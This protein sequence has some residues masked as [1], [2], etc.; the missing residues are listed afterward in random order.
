M[1]LTPQRKRR[2]KIH[3]TIKSMKVENS[4]RV[5]AFLLTYLAY[6]CFHL[7]RK[8]PSIVKSVLHPLSSTGRSA[9]D[10]KTNPGWEPFNQDLVPEQVSKNGYMVTGS[11]DVRVDGKYSCEDVHVPCTKYVKPVDNNLS[12][13]LGIQACPLDDVGLSECWTIC[14]RQ[15]DT[16]T[17]QYYAQSYD[18][19]IPANAG[20]S[21]AKGVIH[22]KRLETASGKYVV[23][24]KLKTKPDSVDGGV[25]LGLLDSVFLGCYTV[26]LFI[27]GYIGDRMNLR[28]FLSIGMFG[29]SLCMFLMGLA[30]SWKIHTMSYFIGINVMFGFFQSVGWP[31]VVAVMGSWFGHGSRGFIMGVW[32]SHTSIGNILGSVITAAAVGSGMHHEDWPLGY[33]IPG[34]IM[35]VSASVVYCLLVPRPEDVGFVSLDTEDVG[36]IVGDMTIEEREALSYQQSTHVTLNSVDNGSR[37][38]P[39]LQTADGEEDD[40]SSDAGESSSSSLGSSTLGD[41]DGCCMTFVEA[42]SIPGLVP[43]SLSLM[44]SKMCAYSVLYWGPYYLGSLGFTPEKAGYLCSFFDVGGIFGGIAAGYLSD[45]L[46]GRAI[47]AFAFQVV[48]IPVMQAYYS[49]TWSAGTHEFTNVAMMILVGFFI[50]AP[51]ALI[52]TAVSAD[53]GTR[54]EGREHILALVTGIIDGTGSFGAMMQGYIVGLISS[55]SWETVWHFLMVAQAFS[56]LMLVRLVYHEIRELRRGRG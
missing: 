33:I 2:E 13:V 28:V 56:A 23:D 52:T 10:V 44:F 19:P 35:F 22:W 46:N 40:L 38:T 3:I 14:K 49:V 27:S 20:A 42:I 37:T 47:V 53:L 30:Y 51:Y 7:T 29:S 36:S 18:G 48:G 9:Y 11:D 8:V 55:S 15:N 16:C 43:F 1:G 21:D 17:N 12:Y 6:T 24:K 45:K 54:L 5:R 34:I 26:G 4:Y 50:N 25:L 31:C 39:L 32:N 41:R